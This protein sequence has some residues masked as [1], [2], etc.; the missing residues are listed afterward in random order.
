[1]YATVQAVRQPADREPDPHNTLRAV[2]PEGA[3]ATGSLVLGHVDSDEGTVIAFWPDAATALPPDDGFVYR[4]T[5]HLPGR[6]D[7]RRPLFAEIIWL[8]KHGDPRKADAAEHGGRNRLWPAIRDI[9]GLVAVY[10]MRSADDRV[11]VVTLV[12]ARETLDA[13]HAATGR[14]ERLPDE[15]PASLPDWDRA[16]TARVLRAELPTEVRS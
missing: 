12:T 6:A 13:I 7:G 16:E 10:A 15:D 11:V 8:N 4:V 1:M 14:A 9:D 2:L 5:D 3:A